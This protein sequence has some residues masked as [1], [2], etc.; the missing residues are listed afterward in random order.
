MERGGK[1]G[2]ASVGLCALALAALFS[3]ASAEG[4][5]EAAECCICL[6]ETAPNGNALSA[7]DPEEKARD[8]CLPPPEE[9]EANGGA[10]QEAQKEEQDACA[11]QA[12]E[13]LGGG[14]GQVQVRS[15][16][17]LSGPCQEICDRAKDQGISF[18]A[19]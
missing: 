17:C 7:S 13:Q 2:V 14:G 11:N 8:N 12:G 9:E 5:T 10:G 19:P 6:S 16:A 1:I 3:L 4:V 18:E 15:E